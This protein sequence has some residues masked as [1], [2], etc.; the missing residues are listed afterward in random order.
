MLDVVQTWRLN[1]TSPTADPA[2]LT[3]MERSDGS[4]QVDFDPGTTL[5]VLDMQ[6]TFF[7]SSG[8]AQDVDLSTATTLASAIELAAT[9][10]A[11]TAAPR[12]FIVADWTLREMGT[13]I[14]GVGSLTG[15]LGNNGAQ[16]ILE[17][18]FTSLGS[19]TVNGGP[20]DVSDASISSDSQGLCVTRVRTPNL[21]VDT[22]QNQQFPRGVVTFNVT[23]PQS[24]NSINATGTFDG[25][26][27]A[28]LRVDGV[29]TTFRFDLVTFDIDN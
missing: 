16:N 4:I 21:E 20:P 11:T 29:P 28:E 25:T 24:S 13:V 5:P 18:V 22:D 1:T 12:S 8:V 17:S 23:G 3:W 10:L 9:A 27:K 19:T 6:I 2:G 7:N 26:N 15:I 14:F